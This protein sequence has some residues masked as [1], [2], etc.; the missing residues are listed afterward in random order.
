MTFAI[1]FLNL[2]LSSLQLMECF[3]VELSLVLVL[4]V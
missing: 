2:F 3:Q 1:C 4:A